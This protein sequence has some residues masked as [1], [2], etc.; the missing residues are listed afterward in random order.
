LHSPLSAFLAAVGARGAAVPAPPPGLGD[1]LARLEAE[2][3][4]AW[5]GLAVEPAAFA[6]HLGE[7][8]ALEG[9]DLA[10]A[11]EALEGADLYLACACAAG[12]PGALQAFEAAYGETVAAFVARV[13]SAPGFASEVLQL[14]RQRI[15]VGTAEAPPRIRSYAGRGPLAGWVGIAAQ[16]IALNLLEGEKAEARAR[17]RAVADGIAA[18][19]DPELRYLRDRYRAAFE[20]AFERAMGRL[21]ARERALLRLQLVGGLTLEQ[22]GAM[23]K[24]NAST[25]SR[26]IAAVRE[27]LL[28]ETE[29][30]LRA[31]LPLS[32]PEFASLARV[33]VSQID[34][35]VVRLLRE[36]DG[37]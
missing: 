3:R 8:V 32:P 16:R 6:S 24:V 33:L 20:S 21:G 35:S 2:G 37:E 11:L 29:R 23:Y 5:P 15:F 19:L 28:G 27:S 26:W 34:V 17:E 13:S 18:E 7:R 10:A 30:L 25:V 14:L 36:G 22:I 9:A 4:T 31:E 12:Q 1:R